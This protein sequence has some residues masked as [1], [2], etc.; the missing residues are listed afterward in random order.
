MSDKPKVYQGVRVKTTVKELLQKRRAALQAA[1]SQKSQTVPSPDSC[2]TTLPAAHGDVFPASSVPDTYFQP[3]QFA[4]NGH[5]SMEDTF[6]MNAMPSEGLH[7]SST[8]CSPAAWMDGYNIPACMDYYS[9]PLAPLSSSPTHSFNLPSPA[10]YNSYSPPE[11]HSSSSSC[12]SSPSRLDLSTS[13]APESCHYQQHF[14]L[15]HCYSHWPALNE[16]GTAS[17]YT[18]YSSSDCF[19]PTFGEDLYSRRESSSAELCYL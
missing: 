15:Q 4:D 9:N 6:L 12:Y 8:S 1:E 3:R 7:A 19:Y 17:E 18:A 16:A 14:D 5:I 13:F 11:S 10:D 2:P